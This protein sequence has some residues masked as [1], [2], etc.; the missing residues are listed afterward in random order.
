M[1]NFI[2]LP[3]IVIIGMNHQ[4]FGW[5]N[6]AT[7]PAITEKA[8]RSN[9]SLDGY[10][11]TYLDL[12]NGIDTNLLTLWD[13]FSVPRFRNIEPNK[14]IKSIS[15][16]IKA[17]SLIEDEDGHLFIP[18]FRPRHH[19]HDPLRNAGLDNYTDHP[20]WTG[21]PSLFPISW[22]PVGESAIYWGTE[23]R[24]SRWEPKVNEDTWKDAR[25]AFYYSL[26]YENKGQRQGMLVET[27]LIL[28][29][30]VHLIEDMGVPA[31]T[32]NDF[33]DGHYRNCLNYGNDLEKYA[34]GQVK[35]NGNQSPWSGSGP[36]AFDKLAKYFDANV[37]LGDY[38]GD[39]NLPPNT[40]GLSECS[41]YQFL[42]LSTMFGCTGTLYQF[43]HPVKE[44]LGPDI[45]VTVPDG[46]KV[47]FNGSNYGVPHIARESY[48]YFFA[49]G[50][51]YYDTE[52]DNT[53]TTDDV[54]VF[55]DYAN[56]TVPRTIDYAAGLMNYFFRGKL[57]I[58]QIDC[59]GNN[60]VITI[61]N[62]S[63]NSGVSQ[64]LKG[65]TFTLYW[66]DSSGNRTPV[67]NFTVYRPGTEPG[68]G[69]EW[70]SGIQMNYDESTKAV[71]TPPESN[72][73]NQ[74]ILVYEGTI[75]AD[76]NSPD[77]DDTRQI[78]TTVQKLCS[79]CCQSIS[80]CPCEYNPIECTTCS[81]FEQGKTSSYLAVKFEGIRN[82]SDGSL[83]PANGIYCL[84]EQF[85]HCPVDV[86][87]NTHCCWAGFNNT[88][89][90][91]DV[92]VGMAQWQY[93]PYPVVPAILVRIFEEEPTGGLDDTILFI[94]R[95]EV[96]EDFVCYKLPLNLNSILTC[97]TFDGISYGGKVTIWNPCENPCLNSTIWISGHNYI[98]NDKVKLSGSDAFC[99]K[100]YVAHLSDSTNRPGSGA[101][102]QNYWMLIDIGM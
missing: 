52:I 8:V 61:T 23:G 55:E 5:E 35:L 32:R 42:S 34:E 78:A 75:S 62:K 22:I 1:R 66:D 77:S 58:E 67:S 11:K 43:P 89:F 10:L 3:L 21:V 16:W 83:H 56:V 84:E 24:S 68:D 70:N 37:Y 46:N 73:V 39:G 54:G 96:L 71:L 53:N 40:W 47:Y 12:P 86:P 2:L 41:N 76:P 94:Y 44:H 74:Y 91:A 19:F 87:D 51:H 63:S 36:V 99:Y 20:F 15:E 38:L 60:I 59:D 4:V 64:I 17:G 25:N 30:V 50:E 90:Y 7:H 85:G 31:H 80:P 98:L 72:D 93:P 79:T 69:N 65:G 81:W 82:C 9:S 13:M 57:S 14:P 49:T 26:V 101:N 92:S 29:E 97:Y 28:G 18:P 95:G 48:T 33:L 88:N 6:I 27:F 100:C 45:L 102:W